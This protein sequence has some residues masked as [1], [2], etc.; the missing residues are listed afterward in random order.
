MRLLVLVVLASCEK[1]SSDPPPAPGDCSETAEAMLRDRERDFVR[2]AVFGVLLDRCR[3]DR[4]ND[5]MH[6][7]VATASGFE[8]VRR[9]AFEHLAKDH[10][11]TLDRELGKARKGR[12]ALAITAIEPTTGDAEGG[13]MVAVTGTDFIASGPRNAKVYFGS[14]QGRIIRFQSDSKLIV[15]APGG[16]PG[17]TVDVLVIFDPGGE[18]RIAKAFTFE[19]K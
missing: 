16:K 6:R 17:E 7:C 9:C 13:A 19:T 12:A 11:D 10:A 14:R 18:L 2:D 1:S 15:E 5:G 4:W 3:E 8:D